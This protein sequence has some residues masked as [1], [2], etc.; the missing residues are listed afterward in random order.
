MPGVSTTIRIDDDV[1]DALKA[2]AARRKGISATKLANELLKQG[3][4]LAVPATAGAARPA[5]ARPRRHLED[6]PSC[7][8]HPPGRIIN[9]TC[10]ACG[11]KA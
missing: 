9:G 8:P 10:M 2:A 7:P 6:T 3:L 4:G 5:R 11:G 1:N